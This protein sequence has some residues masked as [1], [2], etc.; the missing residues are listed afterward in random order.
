[1]DRSYSGRKPKSIVYWFNDVP[2]IYFPSGIELFSDRV[3]IVEDI[4]SSKEEAL[5]QQQELEEKVKELT[6][7][8][9]TRDEKLME[10][11]DIAD[12]SRQ[13]CN[14][15]TSKY[16]DCREQVAHLIDKAVNSKDKADELTDHYMKIEDDLRNQRVVHRRPGR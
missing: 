5:R 8:I 16:E 15:L 4:L 13:E 11:Q 14:D 9:T 10:I 3:V 2:K 6:Q 7:E 12:M 1:M